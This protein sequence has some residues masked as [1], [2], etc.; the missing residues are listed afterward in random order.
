M[1]IFDQSSKQVDVFP[2]PPWH[3]AQEAAAGSPYGDPSV[4]QVLP[5][6]RLRSVVSGTRQHEL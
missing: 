3:M 6:L 5:F 1:K 2:G 4:T